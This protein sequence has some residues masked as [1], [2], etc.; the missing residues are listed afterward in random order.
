MLVISPFTTLIKLTYFPGDIQK[1]VTV[2]GRW[3][4]DSNIPLVIP[5]VCV[6]KGY[7]CNND[8]KE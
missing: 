7:W 3:I 6:D 4:F 8:D 2:V 5:P 1:R